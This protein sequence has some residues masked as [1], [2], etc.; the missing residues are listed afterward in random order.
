MPNHSE[1]QFLKMRV[2]ILASALPFLCVFAVPFPSSRHL[3]FAQKQSSGIF[4]RADI[5]YDR[6]C[7]ATG[8]G[9]PLHLYVYSMPLC[10]ANIGPWACKTC[11]DPTIKDDTKT[12]QDRWTAADGNDGWEH[13][14]R[15][16]TVLRD[17]GGNPLG[18]V[19]GFVQSVSWY[20]NGP[21]Q[22]DCADIGETHCSDVVTCKEANVPVAGMTLT[23]FANIHMVSCFGCLP[24]GSFDLFSSTTISI[25]LCMTLEAPWVIS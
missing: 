1:L 8:Y 12:S 15:W 21:T 7:N 24:H 3:S 13:V 10:S 14:K 19:Q 11:D 20:W 17:G 25:P 16:W 22:W 6:D 4:P 18:A 23:S 2:F 5:R 9:K